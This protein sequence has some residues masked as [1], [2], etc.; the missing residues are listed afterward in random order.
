MI[1]QSIRFRLQLWHSIVLVVVL[2]GFGVTAWRAA[3]GDQ[4][5]RIDDELQEQMLRSFRLL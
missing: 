1:L 5:R 4:L 3:R 2:L